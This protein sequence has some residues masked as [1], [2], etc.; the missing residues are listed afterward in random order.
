VWAAGAERTPLRYRLTDLR[1]RELVGGRLPLSVSTDLLGVVGL[2]CALLQQRW[3]DEVWG[4]PAPR[5]GSGVLSETYPAAAFTAWGIDATGYKA[6]HRPDEAR[7]AR[8]L[9]VDRLAADTA[10]WLAVDDIADRCVES[11]HVLDALV[12]ALVACAVGAGTTHRPGDDEREVARRE[13]WIHIPAEPLRV[14][15]GTTRNALR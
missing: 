5:D 14:V 4:S 1:T 12:C 6:R 8:R 3:A 9:I 2:R 10:T 13:G 11:D 7:A 15:P